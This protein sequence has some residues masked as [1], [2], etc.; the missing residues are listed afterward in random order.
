MSKINTTIATYHP[1][2]DSFINDP[3]SMKFR[4]ACSHDIRQ[5]DYDCAFEALEGMPIFSH[6]K[7]KTRSLRIKF[8][9]TTN[10]VRERK[11]PKMKKKKYPT[12]PKDNKKIMKLKAKSDKFDLL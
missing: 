7:K 2:D 11:V 8:E 3:K 1:F 4:F 12:K 9:N 10:P 6:S 5:N